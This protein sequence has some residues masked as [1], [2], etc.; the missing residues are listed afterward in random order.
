MFEEP[1]NRRE[2]CSA[3][4]RIEW[5]RDGAGNAELF[6]DGRCRLVA[7]DVPTDAPVVSVDATPAETTERWTAHGSKAPYADRLRHSIPEIVQPYGCTMVVGVVQVRQLEYQANGLASRGTL[8]VPNG[9]GPFPGVLIGH[10]GPGLDDIQRARAAD[11][12]QLGYVGLAMD[13]HGQHSP[14]TDRAAMM[15][16]LDHLS[17]HPDETRA[18]GAAALDVLLAE[19]AIDGSRVAAIGYCYGATITLELARSGIPTTRRGGV[20][21]GPAHDP[22]PGSAQHH[23]PSVDVRRR[24]RPDHSPRAPPRVG[25]GDARRRCRV[26]ARPVRRRAT[27]LHPPPGV[28][29]RH[30]RHRLRPSRAATHSWQAMATLL[31]DVF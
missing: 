5:A 31:A 4:G 17:A 15:A 27:Q 7:A 16:R 19:P 6:V 24:R 21:S 29:G 2:P 8:A 14:F 13:Y 30:P 9:A 26:A 20:P 23:R 12:A 25:A 1:E 22:T 10:E 11:I 28:P 3:R 18:L